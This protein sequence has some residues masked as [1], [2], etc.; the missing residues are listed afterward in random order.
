MSY[1]YYKGYSGVSISLSEDDNSLSVPL[2]DRLKPHLDRTDKFRAFPGKSIPYFGTWDFIDFEKGHIVI[3]LHDDG[4]VGLMPKNKW[5]LE[6]RKLTDSEQQTCVY[7]L[8]SI[9]SNPSKENFQDFYD[10]LQ[11]IKNNETWKRVK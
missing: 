1:G 4:E 5:G 11:S 7:K 2:S 8:D 10:W 6:F 9:T 3:G